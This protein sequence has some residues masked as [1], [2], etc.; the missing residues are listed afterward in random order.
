MLPCNSRN[1]IGGDISHFRFS[2]PV[3]FRVPR[4]R[5]YYRLW[6]LHTSMFLCYDRNGLGTY[7]NLLVGIGTLESC[8][9]RERL[10]IS[11][12]L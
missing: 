12:H 5:G 11:W 3:V 7:F 10:R 6:M 2:P 4:F 9:T 1:V 8:G